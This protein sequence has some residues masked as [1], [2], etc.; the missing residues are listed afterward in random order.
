MAIAGPLSYDVQVGDDMHRR[1]AAQLFHDRGGPEPT[2]EEQLQ[3]DLPLPEHARVPQDVPTSP[4]HFIFFNLL[5]NLRFELTV[6]LHHRVSQLKPPLRHERS[7]PTS[8]H[9]MHHLMTQFRSK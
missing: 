3:R 2:E 4:M 5:R 9:P 8:S 7:P 6:H 1:H